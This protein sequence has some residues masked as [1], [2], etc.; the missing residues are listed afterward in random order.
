MKFHFLRPLM[1][2]AYAEPKIAKNRI[3]EQVCLIVSDN[4]KNSYVSKLSGIALYRN[5]AEN[6]NS[7]MATINPPRS[8]LRAGG[9][10]F[11][12]NV[13]HLIMRIT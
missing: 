12:F 6:S 3:A 5:S 4:A 2:W 8:M 13:N 10:I 11:I 9:V 7:A 1:S